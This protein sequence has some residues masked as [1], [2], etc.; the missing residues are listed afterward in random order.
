MTATMMCGRGAQISLVSRPPFGGSWRQ[1]GEHAGRGAA[2]SHTVRYLSMTR[3]QRYSHDRARA[4]A[5]TH[6]GLFVAINE[7]CCTTAVKKRLTKKR[8]RV[9][10]I[11]I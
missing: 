5:R 7:R 8:R 9:R 2:R 3:R 6:G 4:R 10:D 11:Y 1:S